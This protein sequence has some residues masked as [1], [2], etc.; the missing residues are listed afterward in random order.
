MTEVD[1]PLRVGNQARLR[2]LVREHGDEVRVFSAHDPWA[3]AEVAGLARGGVPSM[4]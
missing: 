2:E 4:P 1:R 3:F